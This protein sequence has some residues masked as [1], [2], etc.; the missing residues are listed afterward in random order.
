MVEI[1]VCLRWFVEI[2]KLIALWCLDR[3]FLLGYD[4]LG[5]DLSLLEL[6][7]LHARLDRRP[8]LGSWWVGGGQWILYAVLNLG[9]HAFRANFWSL[10]LRCRLLS[11]C[12]LSDQWLRCRCLDRLRRRHACDSW[13][14]F[15]SLYLLWL[16]LGH[17]NLAR[18]DLRN[19]NYSLW[20]LEGCCFLEAII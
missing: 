4:G 18:R 1:V 11:L 3:F 19:L 15:W 17:T 7:L 9:P 6:R 13:L 20:I 5:D 2:V 10:S 16:D 14:W 12:C 8:R